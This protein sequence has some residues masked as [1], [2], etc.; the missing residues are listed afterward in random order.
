M[1]LLLRWHPIVP[2]KGVVRSYSSKNLEVKARFLE[3]KME[4][5][6]TRNR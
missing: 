4:S 3:L 6:L 5:Q 2:P 1:Q